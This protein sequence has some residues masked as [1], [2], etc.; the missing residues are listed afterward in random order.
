MRPVPMTLSVIIVVARCATHAVTARTHRHRQ[1]V[2]AA[3]PAKT[4]APE[5]DRH[6]ADVAL[7]RKIKPICNG[8]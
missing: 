3:A 4:I 1:P 8:C 7:D 2:K 5:R 6:P